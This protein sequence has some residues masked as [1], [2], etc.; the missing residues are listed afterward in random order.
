MERV[1]LRLLQ[2]DSQQQD[3]YRQQ[4]GDAQQ[5]ENKEQSVITVKVVEAIG[6][7][8][9]GQMARHQGYVV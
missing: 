8:K 1:I 4:T 5:A 6:K 9:N 2:E 7:L 3:D